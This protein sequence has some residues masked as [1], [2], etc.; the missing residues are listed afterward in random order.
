[1]LL[2]TQDL[3]WKPLF[4]KLRT[5]FCKTNWFILYT[6]SS[7]TVT[8]RR[9]QKTATIGCITLDYLFMLICFWTHL[10]RG[11]ITDDESSLSLI[12]NVQTV[13]KYT[14]KES[15]SVCDCKW[16]F[17]TGSVQMISHQ[18][19]VELCWPTIWEVTTHIDGM[20]IIPNDDI[21]S[22]RRVQ[23]NGSSII[24]LWVL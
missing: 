22:N 17:A 7:V 1:M 13:H 6:A 12:I 24:F 15:L 21:A 16:N 19:P 14:I 9:K 11:F 8:R 18:I 4:Y 2:M 10:L 23:T 20:C 5:C 3:N